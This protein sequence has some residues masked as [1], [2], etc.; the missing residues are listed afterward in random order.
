[1]VCLDDKKLQKRFCKILKATKELAVKEY[2][3]QLAPKEQFPTMV[4]SL[5][6]IKIIL[7]VEEICKCRVEKK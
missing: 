3:E 5:N 7:E 6:V 2:L 1:M 4:A